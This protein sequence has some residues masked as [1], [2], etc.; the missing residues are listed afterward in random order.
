LDG[1]LRHVLIVAYSGQ[2]ATPRAPTRGI[3]MRGFLSA[4]IPASPA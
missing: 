3:V 4:P 1:L 2:Y